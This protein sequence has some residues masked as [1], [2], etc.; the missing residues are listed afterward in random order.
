MSVPTISNVLSVTSQAYY[1]QMTMRETGKM[2]MWQFLFPEVDTDTSGTFSLQRIMQDI[3]GVS[4]RY[5]NMQSAVRAYQ[6][7]VET[8]IRIPIASEKTPI[9]EDLE[10]AVIAGIAKN[11]NAAERAAKLSNNID[12]QFISAFNM[13]KNKQAID[14]FVESKFVA[15]GDSNTNIGLDLTYDRDSDLTM[16]YNFTTAG[17]SYSKA[18]ADIQGTYRAN[19]GNVSEMFVVLGDSWRS[20]RLTDTALIEWR[21]ANMA[22]AQADAVEGRALASKYEGLIFLGRD[23]IDGAETPVWVFGYAPGQDFKSHDGATAVPFIADAKAIIGSLNDKRW[24]VQRGIKAFTGSGKAELVAGELVL[25]S[26]NELDPI[27]TFKRCQTRHCF[28]PANPNQ[29]AS[30]TG[31]FA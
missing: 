19:G 6:P 28:V 26:F 20:A 21:K 27:I 1:A 24:T 16:A 7:G 8:T 10:D 14:V 13:T 3:Y 31:T 25:D 30:C 2:Q 23:Y 29:T 11:A 5:H 4:Y 15:K 18:L 12:E 17:N 22:I 9:G